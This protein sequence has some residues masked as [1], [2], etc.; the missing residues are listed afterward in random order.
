MLDKTHKPD[1]DAISNWIG[2][3]N[4]ERWK[5]ILQF[6]EGS[7]PDT[8]SP[9]DWLFGGKKHGWGLR[10]KKSRSFCTLVPER[11][12]LVIIIVLGG[13]EREKVDAILHELSPSIYTEYT[14]AAT[15]HDGKWLAIAVDS[16]E[17]MEDMK[18]LLIIKRKPKQ[19][20]SRS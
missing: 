6:I 16:D 15:Y 8:F 4:Y 5:Q 9:D 19:A 13:G 10:F 2:P 20:Q 7:Y 18:K 1:E 14:N 3:E 17:S 11:N 12:R